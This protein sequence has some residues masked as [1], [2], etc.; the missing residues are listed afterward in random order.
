LLKKGAD[1][2]L[3]DFN[4]RLTPMDVV[5]NDRVRELLIVY[6]HQND[7]KGRER[8]EDLEWMNR[9]IK[10]EKPRIVL[11][12][13]ETKTTSQQL[14]QTENTISGINRERFFEMMKKIQEA[15]VKS[16]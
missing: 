12:E 13:K 1:I 3:A 6:A 7:L 14:K 2:T 4:N 15:G 10:N 8:P 16:R 9:A 11:E 5:Q